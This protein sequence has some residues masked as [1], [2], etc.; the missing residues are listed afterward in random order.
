[1]IV[2]ASVADARRQ[3][4]SLAPARPLASALRCG[5]TSRASAAAGVGTS[6]AFALATVSALAYAAGF[7]PLSWSLAPWLALAP[8]LVA[9][10]ALSPF[11]AS[12]AR[13]RLAA[14]ARL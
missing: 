9:C 12:P 7:P 6:T 1:P 2:R 11:R 8:L 13:L 4:L 14:R 3:V 5:A 10:A